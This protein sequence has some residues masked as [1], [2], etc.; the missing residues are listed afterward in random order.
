MAG[1]IKSKQLS[2]AD[3]EQFIAAAEGLHQSIVRP[4]ISPQCDHYRSLKALH[5]YC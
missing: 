2:Q 5:G 4:L 1:R 3:L